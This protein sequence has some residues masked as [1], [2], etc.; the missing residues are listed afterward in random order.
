MKKFLQY[1]YRIDWAGERTEEQ[2]GTSI[3]EVVTGSPVI[4]FPVSPRKLNKEMVGA[5]IKQKNPGVRLKSVNC[6]LERRV[7]VL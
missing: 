1:R 6:R 4:R 3:T 7:I 2:D 5:A